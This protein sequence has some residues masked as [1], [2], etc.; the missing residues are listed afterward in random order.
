MGFITIFAIFITLI[1][2]GLAE[3]MESSGMLVIGG[4]CIVFV[5]LIGWWPAWSIVFIGLF[6]GI[7]IVMK[8]DLV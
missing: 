8:F 3:E 1:W 5:V 4:I 7:V 6:L 2:M